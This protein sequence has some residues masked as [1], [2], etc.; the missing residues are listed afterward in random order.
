MND[1]LGERLSVLLAMTETVNDPL[2]VPPLLPFVTI[3]FW[4]YAR[5]NH[6]VLPTPK[7]MSGRHSTVMV[8]TANNRPNEG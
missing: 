5:R 4:W 6:G 8:L 1:S 7:G 2:L 3:T